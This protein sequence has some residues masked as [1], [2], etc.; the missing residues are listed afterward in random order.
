MSTP[1]GALVPTLPA[2][3]STEE[4][5]FDAAD[6][7]LLRSYGIDTSLF[8]VM[9]TNPEEFIPQGRT[10]AYPVGKKVPFLGT[11]MGQPVEAYAR[12]RSASLT[13][14]SLLKQT[15]PHDGHEYTIVSGVMRNVGID[16]SVVMRNQ[17]IALP[18]LLWS[19]VNSSLPAEQ[20][21]G[22]ERFIATTAGMGIDLEGTM[23]LFFQHFGAHEEHT[24]E[25]FALFEE[26]GATSDYERIK[27]PRRIQRALRFDDGL[28]VTSFE[29]GRA[30]RSKS[31]TKQ[32]FQDLLDAVVA[33]FERIVTLRRTARE[34]ETD[35]RNQRKERVKGLTEAKIAAKQAEI[36]AKRDASRQWASNYAGAQE[37]I[38]IEGTNLVPQGTWDPVSAPCGRIEVVLKDG[39]KKMLDFWSN[40]SNSS[41][42]APQPVASSVEG[43]PPV[44]GTVITKELQD[45]SPF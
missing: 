42:K 30:D 13:R 25:A 8:E 23:P 14:L 21:M 41:P 17:E 10:T 4:T 11:L 27:D 35:L 26:A 12:T 19:F 43:A 22:Y 1:S 6:A 29:L 34:M 38:K 33:N 15:S 39:T 2:S 32:G 37:R 24:D 28:E 40:S 18:Q 45:A 9:V 31:R 3:V 36:D 7:E 44:Q 20:R 5:G 16:I